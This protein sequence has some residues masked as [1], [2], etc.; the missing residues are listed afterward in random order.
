MVAVMQNALGVIEQ[1]SLGEQVY[2]QIAKALLNGQMRPN[3]KLTIRGLAEKFGVSTTPVRDAIK[4][5][6]QE[7]VLEQRTAKDVRVPL[8][9]RE[10]YLEI[11]DIRLNLEGLAAEHAAQRATRQQHATLRALLQRN[12]Q[13][14]AANDHVLATQGNQEFHLAL[15]EVA[16]MLN[17]QRI[18]KGLWLRMGP[19]VAVYYDS[20]PTGLNDKHYEVLAAM[21]AGDS[22][23]ARLAIQSDILAAKDALLAQID[24]FQA[25]TSKSE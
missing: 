4:Q 6:I 16:N 7:Q 5:M 10:A 23:T 19:M 24:A 21:E 12:D 25:T 13:A 17:L 14:A 3:D 18:L 1:A 20:Q 22:D 11:L 2:D 8:M 9:T 15:S